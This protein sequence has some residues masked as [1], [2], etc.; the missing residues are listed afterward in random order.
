M[1]NWIAKNTGISKANLLKR[2][3]LMK[4]KTWVMSLRIKKEGTY[5]QI[6]QVRREEKET[7]LSST[8]IHNTTTI[9]L[10]RQT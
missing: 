3:M 2:D 8:E 7:E 1:A 6:T 10:K 5:T 4:E 9:Y